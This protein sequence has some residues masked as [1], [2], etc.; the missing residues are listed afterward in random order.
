MA[1]ATSSPSRKAAAAAAREV[2]S[3]EAD[4]SFAGAEALYERGHRLLAEARGDDEVL[5]RALD[6]FRTAR[7]LYLDA[8]GDAEPVTDPLYPAALTART[9]AEMA[10]ERA[11]EAKSTRR[12]R[13]EIADGDRSFAE[14]VSALE[15][16]RGTDASLLEKALEAFVQ[17]QA[18]FLEAGRPLRRGPPPAQPRPPPPRGG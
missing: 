13:K 16:S 1:K 4:E 5:R 10:R 11:A 3:A 9:R 17:A 18:R 15:A 2:E 7:T 14:G 8:A 12:V 6:A